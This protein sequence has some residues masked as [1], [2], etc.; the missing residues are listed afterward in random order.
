VAEVDAES[1]GAGSAYDGGVFAEDV[2]DDATARRKLGSQLF[3]GH[4]GNV[5]GVAIHEVFERVVGVVDS[6]DA[7]GLE[8]EVV[9]AYRR[10]GI[11]L[12]DPA[13]VAAEFATILRHGL[14]D[15]LDGLSLDGLTASGADRVANEMRFTLPLE[16]TGPKADRLTAIARLVAE[17]DADGAYAGFF[18]QLAEAPQQADR[19]FQGFLTGSIDLVAQ[20]GDPEAPRFVVL[21]YKSNL[22]K[23]ATTYAPDQLVGEMALSGYPLQGLLY[24]VALHRYLARRMRGFAPEAHLGGICYYYV[25]G[26]A[27]AGAAP[28]D[29]LARW[30]IPAA[31]IVGCSDI[32]AGRREA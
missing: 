23:E 21:D 13:T 10:A 28:G 20:V 8:A 32:L 14:G 18:G 11:T 12:D 1:G 17:H 26:A 19:L 2:A 6:S 29:G 4:A 3:G 25:R 31:V 27:L 22:L 7:E 16:G 5:V 9:E 30:D 24:S 15:Q